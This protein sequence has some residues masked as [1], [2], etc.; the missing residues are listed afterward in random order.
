MNDA[1]ATTELFTGLAKLYDRYRPSYPP[2]AIDAI[3]GDLP[4]SPDVVD[5]GAGTGISSRALAAGG[6]HVL[7]IEP[8]ADMR[9]VARTHGIDARDGR[10]ESTGLLSKSA[11]AVVAFQAFHWFTNSA[12]V[13]EFARVLRPRGRIALVW[14]ERDTRND[15]F[16]SE[17]RAIDRRFA[18]AA[19]RLAGADFFDDTLAS[20][21]RDGGYGRVRQLHF[22][23]AQR[24]DRDGLIGRT[25]SASYAPREE[26]A[27]RE[28]TVALD[29]LH[30]RYADRSGH[31]TLVYRTDV[32]IA[33]PS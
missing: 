28:L 6:A 30:E 1:L 2:A 11:D 14:N 21:L 29:D 13:L 15:P 33:T 24:L 5:I 23:N 19:G 26:S 3:L 17:T 7:A 32:I 31:V 12:A 25:L 10:A 16:T 8:N 9:A 27:M 18:P 22:T 20:L 4:P